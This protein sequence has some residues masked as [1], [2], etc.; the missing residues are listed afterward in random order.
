[1]RSEDWICETLDRLAAEG[2][3]RSLQVYPPPAGPAVNFSSN[4]YLNLSAHPQ[5]VAAMQAGH[6]R[7]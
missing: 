6:R 4:D 2:L 3:E 5:V 7:R 1:M